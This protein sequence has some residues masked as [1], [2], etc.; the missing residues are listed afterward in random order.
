MLWKTAWCWLLW[1]WWLGN[2][3]CTCY[4]S[5]IPLV[6][7]TCWA[8]GFSS[9]DTHTQK[10]KPHSKQSWDA[11]FQQRET[12]R[13]SCNTVARTETHLPE[14]SQPNTA[15]FFHLSI[16]TIF[17]SWHLCWLSILSVN[18]I[19]DPPPSRFSLSKNERHTL[20]PQTRLNPTAPKDEFL[21]L[22]CSKLYFLYF[23]TP[24]SSRTY[25]L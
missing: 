20:N 3:L 18:W 25:C 10:K 19:S 17:H 24:P 23:L 13:V 9:T 5:I 4:T 2:K 14:P 12:L 6:P 8:V 11:G 15:N 22:W 1:S 7:P 21:V 16:E